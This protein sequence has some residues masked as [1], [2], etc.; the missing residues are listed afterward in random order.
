MCIAA[1]LDALVRALRTRERTA[2]R[3]L[4][5]PVIRVPVWAAETLI[6]I[7]PDS[8]LPVNDRFGPRFA[9]RQVLDFTASYLRSLALL[10]AP[11]HRLVKV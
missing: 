10:C 7:P 5:A 6:I 9:P 3:Y 2:V 1:F 11:V 8:C 4:N